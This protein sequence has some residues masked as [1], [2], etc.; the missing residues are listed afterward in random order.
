MCPI[1]VYN[2]AEQRSIATSRKSS[3]QPWK[4]TIIALRN[5]RKQRFKPSIRAPGK[6]QEQPFLLINSKSKISQ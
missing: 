2:N 5:D 3:L 6:D 1:N 4:L